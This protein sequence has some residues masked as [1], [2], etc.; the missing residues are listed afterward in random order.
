MTGGGLAK[1]A[2][3]TLYIDGSAVGSGR[4]EKTLPIVFSADET[5]DVG[6]KRGSPIT[7]DMTTE[8]NAFTGTVQLVV[9]ETDPKDQAEHLISR[10][11]LLNILMARQ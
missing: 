10:E 4:V 6:I 3:V 1:G 11:H 2:T 9:I 7:P 5:S 8:N